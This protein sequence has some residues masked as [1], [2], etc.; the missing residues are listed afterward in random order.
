MSTNIRGGPGFILT[1]TIINIMILYGHI[2]NL[3][4]NVY[5]EKQLKDIDIIF[6][7]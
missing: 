1:N 4:G 2:I 6:H 7:F 5:S 3:N